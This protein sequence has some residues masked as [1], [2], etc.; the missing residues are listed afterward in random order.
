MKPK[1]LLFAT[2]LFAISCNHEEHKTNHDEKKTDSISKQ[3]VFKPVDSATAMKNWTEYMT[4]TDMHKMISSWDGK[5]NTEINS[6]MSPDAPPM[7][8]EGK[9]INK[10]VLGGRY[11]ESI[12]TSNMMGMPFEG[13]GTLG[14]DNAKKVFES[15]WIDNVG[16]GVIKMTGAWDAASKSVTLKGMSIDPT[17]G[18]EFEM[19]EVF[20]VIDENT[21]LME[22]YGPSSKDGKEM[23][24][25]EMKFTRVK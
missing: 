24:M 9:T 25:M 13:H 5:W 17:T 2:V 19:K 8:S 3:E 6:W 21:H 23:K 18:K 11:Q 1:H 20:K 16:T 4:P 14:Y 10:M 12:H 7:K 22:M 15:T